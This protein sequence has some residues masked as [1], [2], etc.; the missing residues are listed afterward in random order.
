MPKPSSIR[1]VVSIQHRLVTD[2]QTDTR[3]QQIPRSHSIA[4]RGK[5]ESRRVQKIVSVH[6]RTLQLEMT[7][8][9]FTSKNFTSVKLFQPYLQAEVSGKPATTLIHTHSN[10]AFPIAIAIYLN[11]YSPFRPRL[12]IYSHSCL[13]SGLPWVW[14]SPWA[15]VWAWVWV[16]GSPWVWVW[17]WAWVWGQK[18]RPH[19]S[20]AG[21]AVRS[22]S[23]QTRCK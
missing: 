1:P 7:R 5:K 4:S 9:M 17:A 23:Q 12:K 3:R 18:L 6:T 21:R 20:P 11:F 16:W 14:G 19:G 8:A 10:W 22:G 2:G 13:P 15:W